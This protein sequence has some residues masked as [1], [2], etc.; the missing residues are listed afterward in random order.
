MSDTRWGALPD[1]LREL[2]EAAWQEVATAHAKWHL[3][4]QLFG[5][6]PGR[7]AVLNRTAPDFFALC[8]HT[9]LTDVLITSGRLLDRAETHGK[10]NLSLERL[11][12]VVHAGDAPHLAARLSSLLAD[13]RAAE[14]TLR[15]HRNR[16]IAHNDLLTLLRTGREPLPIV[17]VRD[18]DSVLGGLAAFLNAIDAHYCGGGTTVFDSPI[19]NGDGEAL[20]HWLREAVVAR[21]SKM[22]KLRTEAGLPPMDPWLPPED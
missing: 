17:T 18:V 7:V 9:F 2:F 11:R 19:Q 8:Q 16:R 15:E 3:A 22:N 6:S 5:T 10:K 21:E 13:V 12:D 1:E 20:L 14:A 4:K